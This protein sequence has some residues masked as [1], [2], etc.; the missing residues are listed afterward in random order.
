MACETRKPTKQ[1]QALSVDQAMPGL[2]KRRPGIC[3]SPLPLLPEQLDRLT[4][5]MHGALIALTVGEYRESHH[6][7]LVLVLNVGMVLARGAGH[8]QAY[9]QWRTMAG[10]FREQ[11]TLDSAPPEPV[12]QRLC[13]GFV[14]LE[15]YFRSVPAFK[16][17]ESLDAVMA[18]YR[19][20]TPAAA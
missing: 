16:V 1:R 2:A 14:Q 20:R 8:R 13:A 18:V 7:D 4:T 10:Q 12:R 5:A 3:K 9:E 15:A 19:R 6:E 11:V 17:I